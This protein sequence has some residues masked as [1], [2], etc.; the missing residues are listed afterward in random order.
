M[1]YISKLSCY[2]LLS[3]SFPSLIALLEDQ[4]FEVRLA[5]CRLLET[6]AEFQAENMLTESILKTYMMGFIKMIEQADQ[7]FAC[8]MCI[9]FEK[10]S[11]KIHCANH[12]ASFFHEKIP[13]L[14]YTLLNTAFKAPKTQ[15][16]NLQAS[17]CRTLIAVVI[18]CFDTHNITEF[19]D[20]FYEGLEKAQEFTNKDHRVQLVECMCLCMSM[21]NYRARQMKFTI[22]KEALYKCYEAAVNVQRKER[23]ILS[24]AIFLMGSVAPLLG[25]DFF[26]FMEDFLAHLK[27][28][29]Q[30]S[31]NNHVITTAFESLGNLSRE[32]GGIDDDK[33]KN[34]FMPDLLKR[35]TDKAVPLEDRV[36]LFTVIGDLCLGNLK[37]VIHYVQQILTDFEA[38]FSAVCDMLVERAYSERKRELDA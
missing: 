3:D 24:E 37:G 27:E 5:T 15:E 18:H 38:I 26:C 11:E 21:I 9:M 17:A 29:I 6:I 13:D 34:V 2:N 22:P 35:L 30:N 7:V 10:L 25:Q 4:D 33:I 1:R 20:K 28:G 19:L 12:Q 14:V 36:T 16:M 23:Q 32:L 31:Q 8:S